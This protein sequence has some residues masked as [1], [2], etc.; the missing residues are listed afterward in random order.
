[1][2]DDEVAPPPLPQII[3]EEELGDTDPEEGSPPPPDASDHR[4][5]LVTVLNPDPAKPVPVFASL[6]ST[7]L[8]I[9]FQYEKAPTTGALHYHFY[10]RYKRSQSAAYVTKTFEKFCGTHPSISFCETPLSKVKAKAY[11]R[12][13]CACDKCHGPR[14]LKCKRGTCPSVIS[15][16]WSYGEDEHPGERTDLQTVAKLVYEAG[17]ITAAP[18]DYQVRYHT[19]LNLIAN[20]KKPPIIRPLTIYVLLGPT[21]IGKSFIVR[22]LFP[23]A[24][25]LKHG[26]TGFWWDGYNGEKDVIV[27]EFSGGM[28]LSAFNQLFDHYRVQTDAK[29]GGQWGRFENIFITTNVHPRFWYPNL[30]MTPAGPCT[31]SGEIPFPATIMAMFRRLGCEPGHQKN[32][33]MVMKT[34]EERDRKWDLNPELP[35][36]DTLPVDVISRPR[37]DAEEQDAW[38]A[39]ALEPPNKKHQ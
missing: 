25:P 22:M 15:G 20:Q 3:D 8:Q 13:A 36:S 26:N 39:E 35:R 2:Q 7:F 19:G 5:W 23:D 6:H 33:F 24:Y 11:C 28:P 17:T 38:S 16:P 18:L 14:A 21:E 29:H 30:C 12:K 10:V 4:N 9:V 34:R 1:M 27:E 31:P 37:P 32:S